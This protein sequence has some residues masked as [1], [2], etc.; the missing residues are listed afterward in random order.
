MSRK[1]IEHT[2]DAEQ[3]IGTLLQQFAFSPST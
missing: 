2:Q 1:M 3:G